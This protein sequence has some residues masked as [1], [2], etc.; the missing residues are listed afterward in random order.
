MPFP[1]RLKVVLNPD[2]RHDSLRGRLSNKDP[3]DS[4]L[5]LL[6]D[7][8]LD[9]VL[10]LARRAR[11]LPK[12]PTNYFTNASTMKFTVELLRI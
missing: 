3:I 2:P 8:S 5:D 1:E 10:A 7:D 9:H 4:M 6:A 12:Q 11:A